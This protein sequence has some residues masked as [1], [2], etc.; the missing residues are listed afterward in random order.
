MQ[1][2]S[3]E[4][5]SS[6]TAVFSNLDI[7]SML[8]IVLL[9]L[10]GLCAVAAIVILVSIVIVAPIRAVSQGIRAFA[11]WLKSADWKPVRSLLL[12]MAMLAAIGLTSVLAA[13][14]VYH[15]D[16]LA[17]TLLIGV[18]GLGLVLGGWFILW[19]LARKTKQTAVRL[20]GDDN[21]RPEE[22]AP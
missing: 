14:A 15:A 4:S 8:E 9:V 16:Q 5:V 11:A 18:L 21:P 7:V 22:S 17:E 13:K 6:F 3:G 12:V 1:T 2:D 10:A 19:R 20:V